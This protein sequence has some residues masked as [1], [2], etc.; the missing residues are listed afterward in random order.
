MT[1]LPPLH[2][3]NAVC[4]SA[5]I[6]PDLP[7]SYDPGGSTLTEQELLDEWGRE[8]TWRR[9]LRRLA[10]DLVRFGKFNTGATVGI[11]K[12]GQG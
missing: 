4:A 6:L 11:S 9:E 10:Q 2:L 3:L 8:F 5:T 12:P 7:V 1:K